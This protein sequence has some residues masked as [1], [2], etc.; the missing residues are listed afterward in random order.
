MQPRRL[1]FLLPITTGQ[2][3]IFSRQAYRSYLSI[4]GTISVLFFSAELSQAAETLDR[5]E[6]RLRL[7]E[8]IQAT[9]ARQPAISLGKEQLKQGA[10]SIDLALADFDWK[11]DA[12]LTHGTDYKPT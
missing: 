10:S 2:P 12:S 9:L 1:C 11:F 6:P 8:V 3:M 7:T 5:P 4:I